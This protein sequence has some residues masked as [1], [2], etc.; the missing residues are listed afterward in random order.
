MINEDWVNRWDENRIG[1]HS[2]EYNKYLIKYFDRFSDSGSDVLLPLCGKSLDLLYLRD[3]VSKV[4]GV[5]LSSKAIGSFIQENNLTYEKKENKYFDFYKIDNIDFFV[6]DFFNLEIKS[7]NRLDIF[8]RASLVAL[9]AEQRVQ[10]SEKIKTI[11]SG[12]MLLVTLEYPENEKK[13]PP[14]SVLEEEVYSLYEDTFDITLLESIDLKQT[15]DRLG[16][17]SFAYEKVFLI[18][19]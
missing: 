5:E 11:L 16:S 4:I 8:D 18:S 7:D 14:F 2:L 3:K 17:L 19:K 10:Y 13:G 9:N 6:G 15:D 12:K 1:F